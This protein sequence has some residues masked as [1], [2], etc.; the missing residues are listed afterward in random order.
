MLTDVGEVLAA[1]DAALDA[2]QLPPR[3]E[4]PALA[5]RTAEYVRADGDGRREAADARSRRTSRR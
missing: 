3:V 4:G 1:A 5:V 2:A